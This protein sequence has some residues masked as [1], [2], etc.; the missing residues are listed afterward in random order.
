MY[1]WYYPLAPFLVFFLFLG[2]LSLVYV[3]VFIHGLTHK[4]RVPKKKSLDSHC[5]SDNSSR[6]D[7]NE[8]SLTKLAVNQP[9]EDE[10]ANQ[11]RDGIN[12]NV[13]SRD[14]ESVLRNRNEEHSPTDTAVATFSV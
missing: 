1:K 4:A 8:E 11:N 14:G 2:F 7:K 9:A 6:A 3:A 12:V 5:G 10:G 13:T